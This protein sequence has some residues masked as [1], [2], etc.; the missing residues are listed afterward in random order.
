M[1]HLILN[2]NMLNNSNNVLHR[3]NSQKFK[4]KKDKGMKGQAGCKDPGRL[5]KP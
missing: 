4:K 2:L 1:A 5:E 3:V